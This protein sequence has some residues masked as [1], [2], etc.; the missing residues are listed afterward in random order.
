MLSP[1]NVRHLLV[2]FGIMVFLLKL[3]GYTIPEYYLIVKV[4]S[5]WKSELE[6]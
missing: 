5:M 1:L 6:L 3:A 2:T 4:D